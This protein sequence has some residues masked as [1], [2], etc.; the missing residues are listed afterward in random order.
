[1]K[2][3]HPTW[4]HRSRGSSSRRMRR[5]ATRAAPQ[6]RLVA[7]SGLSSPPRSTTGHAVT[8]RESSRNG[9]PKSETASNIGRDEVEQ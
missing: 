8:Q 3:Y 5:S 2:D 9:M 6:D 4:Y 1:M 7:K